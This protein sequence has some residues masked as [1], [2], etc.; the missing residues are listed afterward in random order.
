MIRITVESANEDERAAIA[1]VI[2]TRLQ[3][4]G[5]DASSK[6]V[7]PEQAA[8]VTTVSNI[9][10][11]VDVVHKPLADTYI[12]PIFIDVQSAGNDPD[13]DAA[14]IMQAMT[15]LVRSYQKRRPSLWERI[16]AVFS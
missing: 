13:R 12:H 10:D 11:T 1:K 5:V 6:V 9:N 3:T 8:A 14:A 16:K 4:Q 2:I 15:N 7:L